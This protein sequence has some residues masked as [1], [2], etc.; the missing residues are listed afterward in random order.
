MQAIE[1]Q[2]V[3]REDAAPAVGKRI[4]VRCDR[5]GCGH[6]ALIDPRKVFSSRTQWPAQGRSGRFRCV[7]GSRES[8]VFYTA[9]AESSEGV[10]HPAALAL[11]F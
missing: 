7:C 3:A 8:L 10:L 4:V 9:H 6:A 11:W 1:E 2:R 5:Q